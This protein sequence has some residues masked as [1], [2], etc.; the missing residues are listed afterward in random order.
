VVRGPVVLAPK[1]QEP[2][3]PAPGA[4]AQGI[5]WYQWRRYECGLLY[6]EVKGSVAKAFRG[7][8]QSLKQQVHV[9]TGLRVASVH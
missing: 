5:C 4:S 3:T 9:S 7:A 6:S 1:A 8:L 2:K